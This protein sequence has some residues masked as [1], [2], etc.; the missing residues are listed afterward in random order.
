MLITFA[1]T[2]ALCEIMCGGQGMVLAD[3][4]HIKIQ[5]DSCAMHAV[6]LGLQTHT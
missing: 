3:I 2:R 6:Y 4:P 1:E 5:Y